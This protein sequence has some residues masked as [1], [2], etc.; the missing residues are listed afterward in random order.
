VFVRLISVVSLFFGL[1][2]FGGFVRTFANI[3]SFCLKKVIKNSNNIKN[4]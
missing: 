4:N 3:K 1:R 2:L